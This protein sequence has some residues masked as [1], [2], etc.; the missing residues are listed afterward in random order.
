M[1]VQAKSMDNGGSSFFF[2]FGVDAWVVDDG[3]FYGLICEGLCL[4]LAVGC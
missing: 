4:W 2:F 1:V 3:Y